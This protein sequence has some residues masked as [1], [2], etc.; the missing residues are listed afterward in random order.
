MERRAVRVIQIS[1]THLSRGKAHFTDNWAP[2]ARWI[3]SERP[4][5][6]I[7][8]GDVTVDGAEIDDDLAY[9]ADLMA[10]L[11]ARWRALP[12]NHDV[13]ETDHRHQPV[14]DERLAR[15]RVRFG[16][17]WWVEE[18]AGWRLIGLDALLFGSDA[19]EEAA[20]MDW[21]E[22]VMAKSAASQFAWFLHKPLFIDSPGE[23]D[24]G[25]WSVKPQPRARLLAL[26]ERYRVALVASGHLHKARDFQLGPT[27]YLWA[28]ASSFLV[29]FQPP[30]PGEKRLGAVCYEFGESG[31]SA[32]VCEVPGLAEHW[33]DHVLDDVYPRR[34]DAIPTG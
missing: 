15:W 9:A 33:L 20:Q 7:H 27:R 22:E 14:T 29:G 1:D 32:R 6:V 16:A 5:L 12:G 17:D 31:F 30:M 24:T 11:P 4:D 23:G 28:P 21:L 25:Y 18:F 8:T 13:G 19:A 2:L 26:V 10:G 34:P 3:G